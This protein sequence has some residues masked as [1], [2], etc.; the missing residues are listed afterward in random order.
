MKKIIF[1]ICIVTF[2]FMLTMAVS[3][4]APTF[5]P[6]GDPI[7]GMGQMHI[8]GDEDNQTPEHCDGWYLSED[9]TELN[10]GF[11]RVELTYK[12]GGTTYKV[13]Y[14]TYYVLENDST[15]TWN[16]KKVSEYL[17]V[18]IGVDNISKIEIPY[19]T[20]V[21]PERAFV[22]PTRW[23]PITSA[24]H[25]K[26]HAA[27]PH[28]NLTY[29]YLE[30]TVLRIEDFAF[31]HC[32]NLTQVDS[33]TLGDH[34]GEA[35]PTMGN[36]NHQ[37]LQ[38]IGYRAFHHCSLTNFNFNK[39]LVYI[40]EGA[41]EGN[42][43]TSINLAKCVELK[44]IPKHC[45]HETNST[46]TSIILPIY[47]ERLEDY[48][49]TGSSADT[50][51]LGLTL[52][53]VGHEAFTT[54]KKVKVFIIPTTIETIFS[55]SF[56]FGDNSYVPVV[57]PLK[58]KSAIDD[59]FARFKEQGFTGLKFSNNTQQVYNRSEN[60]WLN[61]LEFCTKYLGGHIADPYSGITRIEY[62]YGINHEGTAYG[63]ACAVCGNSTADGKFEVRPI[64]ISK[65]YSI[66]TY[67]GLYAFANGFEIYHNALHVYQQVY[68]EVELGILFLREA[69]YKAGS[70]LRNDISTMGV[71]L[72]RA[73]LLQGKD[74]ELFSSMDFI[75][76]YSKGLG[77]VNGSTTNRGD[78][79]VVIAAY[80]LH[81]NENAKHPVYDENGKATGEVEVLYNTSHYVQDTDDLCVKGTTSDKKY[82]TVSYYS[83]YGEIQRQGLV[84]EGQN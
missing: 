48:A 59:M 54:T 35:G 27:E 19:G 78:E 10:E 49:F 25:P 42:K 13:S 63:G 60:Y 55:D 64:L 33:E 47:L 68:G 34:V 20:T 44:V 57:V 69:V 11:A 80:L 76:T 70:D 14:P 45:F 36:H 21:I 38:H 2:I 37:M 83:I 61:N 74:P 26:G 84:E 43:F 56:S 40:G 28:P 1:L 3:A 46:I 53:Y 77:S 81:K 5:A 32:E 30:N 23:D 75:F 41:F 8:F 29:V 17:G 16:F 9:G 51:F 6:L 71:C 22:D 58:T 52:K 62:P 31:A 67:N 15:L 12:N 65:G 79:P 24:A 18:T 50:V 39:H 66:C 72:D 7:P 4:A 73:T 82:V